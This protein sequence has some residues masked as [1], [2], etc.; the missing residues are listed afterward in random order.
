M[1]ARKEGLKKRFP[2]EYHFL[3]IEHGYVFKAL[4]FINQQSVIRSQSLDYSRPSLKNP[5]K[6]MTFCKPQYITTKLWN[7]FWK[8]EG[9]FSIPFF[10]LIVA[11]TR[12]VK[13]INNYL[14][15]K[16]GLWLKEEWKQRIVQVLPAHAI[17]KTRTI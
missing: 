3:V 11:Q 14:K 4:Y 9:I 10:C 7:S 12:L 1:E 5:H 15:M 8:K 13:Q 6:L 16:T 17:T 2:I